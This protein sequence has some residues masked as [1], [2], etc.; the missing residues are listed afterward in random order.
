MRRREFIALLAGSPVALPL[1]VRAQPRER[2]R[3][4]GVLF[5]GT[6][7][8]FFKGNAWEGFIDTLRQL[9]WADGNNV[10][11]EFRWVESNAARVQ[12]LAK[13][14]VS[15]KPDVILALNPLV[16]AALQRETKTIPIV[17]LAV[18]DPVASGLVA[19]LSHPGGNITG[20]SN[21]DAT[22]VGKYIEILKVI[23]PGMTHVWDM[24]N[25]DTSPTHL[26]S[27]YPL[28]DAAARHDGVELSPAP[29]RNSSDIE[30]VIE[31]IGGT[32]NVGLIVW[33][34]PFFSEDILDL[35]ISLTT[36]YRVPT[37]YPFERLVTAGGLISYGSSFID[38]FKQAAGYIDRIL[39]GANPA[40]LPVQLPTKY[41][42]VINLKA[43]NAMGLR[44][45]STLLGR[46]DEVIE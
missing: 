19:S 23:S 8:L 24:F 30:R 37:I 34:E 11:I 42:M 7:N 9:G 40:D 32:P 27:F 33:G 15:L 12:A 41:E 45:P 2:V 14:I 6:K 44:I 5:G 20:F 39:R 17:F 29:V 28:L 10:Q 35:V 36:R 16:V 46:A 18:G 22:V 3:R 21:F 1:G 4:I 13:E 31:S 25:P 38:Q 43:A 26:T